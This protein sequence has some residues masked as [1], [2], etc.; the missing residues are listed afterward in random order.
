MKKRTTEIFIEECKTVHGDNFTY[1]KTEYKNSRTKV[2][3]TNKY[4]EDLD[5]WPLDFL[6][7]TKDKNNRFTTEFFIRKSKEIFGEDTY[8]YEKTVCNSSMDDVVITCKKHGDFT[9]K[10]YIHIHGKQGCP[11]CSRGINN[12]AEFILRAREVHGWKYDYS[13]VNFVDMGT[14]IT[15]ICPK[16]GE[17]EVLA[18]EHLRGCDCEKC[19]RESRKKPLEKFIR[20]AKLMERNISII[21]DY[22]SMTEKTWFKCGVCGKEWEA[23]PMKIQ[24][25][26]GCSYCNFGVKTTEDFIKR[27]KEVHGDRYDYSKAVYRGNTVPL[28]IICPE[29]G[30]F[31]IPPTTFF[32]R[33]NPCKKCSRKSKMEHD[34][35][36][37]LDARKIH[38]T[39]NKTFP[40]DLGLKSYDFFLDDYNVLIECQ[41]GQHFKPNEF[42][43]GEERFK[44]QQESDKIKKE[45]AKK[46]GIKLLYFAYD[47]EDETFMGEPVFKSTGELLEEIFK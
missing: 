47:T 36:L 3:V 24:G 26:C 4:G 20:D 5:V 17:F 28:T 34:I 18:G 38:Y 9:K 42:F 37:A 45:Y 14:K 13:K 7:K 25:G 43:G 16:H 8:S 44:E 19:V 11:K 41:G 10:A 35:M 6:K 46:N 22:R 33:T 30:E 21:G 23:T 31:D 32:N 27:A 29:H 2:T 39:N 15:V 1:E 12:T 40:K